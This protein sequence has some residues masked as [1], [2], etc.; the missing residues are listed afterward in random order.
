MFFKGILGLLIFS[1]NLQYGSNKNIELKPVVDRWPNSKL[2]KDNQG[3]DEKNLNH[4]DDSR[5]KLEEIKNNHHKYN[6]LKTL[7]FNHVSI[8]HKIYLIKKFNLLN[9]KITGDLL[10]GG[11]MDDWNFEI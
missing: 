9:E 5:E 10:A 8:E 1:P 4:P 6:L 7:E 3:C 2:I 11:L